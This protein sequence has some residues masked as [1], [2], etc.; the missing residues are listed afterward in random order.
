MLLRW[1]EIF[2]LEVEI[3]SSIFVFHED[4]SERG[5]VDSDS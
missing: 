2:S 1:I 4:F 5:R 3:F